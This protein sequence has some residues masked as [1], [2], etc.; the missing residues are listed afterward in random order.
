ML[1]IT[2]TPTPTN[3]ILTLGVFAIIAAGVRA[4]YLALNKL[5]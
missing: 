3:V 2:P 5:T 1:K 4:V